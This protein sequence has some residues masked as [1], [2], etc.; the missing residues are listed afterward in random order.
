MQA[1]KKKQMKAFLCSCSGHAWSGISGAALATRWCRVCSLISPAYPPP[2]SQLTLAKCRTPMLPPHC[3]LTSS[4]LLQGPAQPHAS[5]SCSI[6]CPHRALHS[7]TTSLPHLLSALKYV[8]KVSVCAV[9]AYSA[10]TCPS[11]PTQA[12]TMAAMTSHLSAS[13][14]PSP[15][16][17]CCLYGLKF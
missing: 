6:Y 13:L 17:C 1:F 4:F 7:A 15:G 9:H 2:L 5:S 14:Y 8:C 16:R 3:F 10:K 11:R 12:P